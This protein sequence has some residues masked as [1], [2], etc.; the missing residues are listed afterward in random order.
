[1]V[2]GGGWMVSRFLRGSKLRFFLFAGDV[3]FIRGL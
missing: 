1:M 2:D 3:N